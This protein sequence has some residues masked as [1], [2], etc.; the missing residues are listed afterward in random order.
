M[1]K[2][3]VHRE[4][5]FYPI[6]DREIDLEEDGLGKLLSLEANHILSPVEKSIIINDRY[7]F[8]L[9]AKI[10][11]SHP[12]HGIFLETKDDHDLISIEGL[13]TRMAPSATNKS[14][15]SIQLGTGIYFL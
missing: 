15:L 13:N 3:I 8:D 2:H 7:E 9:F 6:S 4:E 12:I 5:A 1:E 11:P 10:R 14:A